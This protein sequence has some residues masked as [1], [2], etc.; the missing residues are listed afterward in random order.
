MTTPIMTTPIEN[1]T[2]TTTRSR[3]VR[4]IAA[5]LGVG[6]LAGTIACGTQAAPPPQLGQPGTQQPGQQLS[7]GALS[8]NCGAGQQAIIRPSTVNGQA[9]SQVDC[10]PALPAASQPVWG[11]PQPIQPQPPMASTVPAAPAVPAAPTN[12]YAPAPVA[13]APV[14]TEPVR[15]RPA[16]VVAA[17][18]YVEYQPRVIQHRTWKPRRSVQKS[19]VI[20]G[21]SAGIGAAIGGAIN[22]GKGALIG[23]ALGG[24]GAA[25]WDQATRR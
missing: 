10:V 6:A 22:G 5:L 19:A 7:A 1:H 17:N 9:V 23:A 25:I 15:Y 21:S 11:P 12:Y 20:I 3:R 14:M 13:V 24:G 8:V 4:I 2:S 18:D 16:R